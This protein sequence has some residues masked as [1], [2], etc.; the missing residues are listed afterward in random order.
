MHYYSNVEYTDVIFMHGIALEA[1]RL[2]AEAFPHRSHPDR[3]TFIGIHQRLRET[4]FSTL[5]Q[6]PGRPSS[7]A[8][9]VEER[10]LER[11]GVNPGTS[12][13][14]MAIQEGIN[15]P[16]C[17][18][19]HTSPASVQG[20]KNTDFLPRLYFCQQMQHQRFPDP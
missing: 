12:A 5:H 2:Y 11:M 10:L 1:A 14:R 18:V 13:R 16:L 17:M 6:R 19:D 20:L 15:A 4:G 7:I 9:D 3:R 8:P